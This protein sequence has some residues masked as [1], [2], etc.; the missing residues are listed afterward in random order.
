MTDGSEREQ[1]KIS[2]EN[3]VFE[4]ERADD[5]QLNGLRVIQSPASFCFGTDSVLLAHFALE[6]LRKAGKRS[7]IIDLGAGS[8]VLSLLLHAR[9][10]LP[11]T[12][13]ELDAD[14]FSRLRRSLLLN[15]LT[16]GEILPVEA[17][18]LDPALGNDPRLGG[19]FEYAIC[20]PPYFRRDSGK[21]SENGSATHELTADIRSVAEAAARL[22]KYGGKLFVCY[23]CERLAEAFT[24]LCAAGMEPKQL[25][26]VQTKSGSKPYLALIRAVHGGR[27]GLVTEA[28]LVILNADGTY[29]EEVQ[30]Y[31]NE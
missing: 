22:V 2:E 28:P 6:G 19:K 5:L 18:Y 29:T 23:P 17:D 12:A 31:Y 13:V 11:V 16:D 30:K 21:I 20:N 27:P 9:T 3:L 24:A 1:N 15:G 10:G 8:G 4:G 25:R 14:A 26:F 7:R